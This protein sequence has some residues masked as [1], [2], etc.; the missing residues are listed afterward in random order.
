MVLL[1]QFVP[2]HETLAA[3]LP[4]PTSGRVYNTAESGW[5]SYDCSAPKNGLMTCSFVQTGVRQQLK[6]DEARKR[7]SKEAAD[8]EASLAKDYKGAP[9]RMFDSPEWKE[10]CT[11]STDITRAL[12]GE[13]ATSSPAAMLQSLEKMGHREKQDMLRWSEAVAR[14][15]SSRNLDGMKDAL[16]QSL[17]QEQRTCLIR[18]NPFSQTFKP[19]FSNSVFQAWIVADSNPAGEC[20]LINVSRLVPGKDSWQWRY[21]ARKIVTNPSADLLLMSCGDLDQAEYLYDASPQPIH[22]QCDYIKPDF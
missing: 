5:L 10:L 16:T 14:S 6:P 13:P 17:D 1:F 11:M 8:L 4:F 3:D 2:S 9:G 21:Y 18:T 22:L 12:R 15:C 7:F 20:G 19:Q